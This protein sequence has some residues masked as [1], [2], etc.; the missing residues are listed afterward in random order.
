MVPFIAQQGL[1]LSMRVMPLMMSTVFDARLVTH[2]LEAGNLNARYVIHAV[3]PIYD[4]FADP[5][6]V[7][8]SAYQRSLD[9]ALANHCQSVALPAISCGVYGYPPQEAAEVAMA[10]CQRPEYAALDM[11]FYLFSEEM[12]SIWQHALT[13]H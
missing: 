5:K 6:A 10:V 11:R 13:Q 4:K 8:E 7:L 9:L 3:G 2:A 1:R 12:L